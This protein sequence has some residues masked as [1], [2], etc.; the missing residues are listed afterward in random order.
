MPVETANDPPF[1]HLAREMSR[2]LDRMSNPYSN[3]YAGDAWQPNVN[4][5]ET[6]TAYFVCVDLAGVDKESV[7]LTLVDHRLVLRG[8]REVPRC[9]ADINDCAGL[10]TRAK[11]HLMEIDHGPF[12]RD[13]ELPHA[14]RHEKIIANYLNG[15]LWIE[16]P[17][18]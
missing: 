12:S 11:I 18:K 14:I 6:E 16:I 15:M 3:F 17:K 5:Y 1:G 4:L 9:P 2:F 7:D 8:N 10:H 13:V